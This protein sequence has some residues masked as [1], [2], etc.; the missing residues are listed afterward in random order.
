M[1]FGD[2]MLCWIN[3]VHIIAYY[4][5]VLRVTIILVWLGAESLCNGKKQTSEIAAMILI[6]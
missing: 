5:Y 2:V 3:S 6:K 1:Y 4:T